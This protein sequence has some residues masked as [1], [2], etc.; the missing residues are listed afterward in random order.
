MNFGKQFEYD[1]VLEGDGTHDF[2]ELVELPRGADSP[3]AF[4][5]SPV[6]D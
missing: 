2:N 3:I 5:L 6:P 1:L 4:R